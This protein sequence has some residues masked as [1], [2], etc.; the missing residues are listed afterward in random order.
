MK[1]KIFVKT[2]EKEW[3]L[4]WIEINTPDKL[5]AVSGSSPKTMLVEERISLRSIVQFHVV[6]QLHRITEDERSSGDHI[7]QT[8]CSEQ[9]QLE[10]KSTLLRALSSSENLQGGRFRH[11]FGQLVS[12]L[13]HP[14]GVNIVWSSLMQLVITASS[15]LG[16]GCWEESGSVSSV[17]P[18]PLS[19]C[20]GQWKFQH[21]GGPLSCPLITCFRCGKLLFILTLGFSL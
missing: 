1:F 6:H 17:A 2:N 4:K 9:G 11:L 13:T 18:L 14:H 12:V 20:V 15:P 19:V 3:R 10:S 16:A 8:C 21:M 7:D 5:Q